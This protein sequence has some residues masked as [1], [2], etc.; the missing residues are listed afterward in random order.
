MNLFAWNLSAH[1]FS[2]TEMTLE[3]ALI[4]FSNLLFSLRMIVEKF[5][6]ILKYSVNYWHI[7]WR[8]DLIQNILFKYPVILS[9]FIMTMVSLI[10]VFLVTRI[11]SCISDLPIIDPK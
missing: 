6:S 1:K 8:K 2:G 10:I 7:Q 5:Y 11:L 3:T 9:C 4:P